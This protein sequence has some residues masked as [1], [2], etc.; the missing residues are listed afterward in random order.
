LFLSN[1]GKTV[2]GS[3]EQRKGDNTVAA[4]LDPEARKSIDPLPNIP[5]QKVFLYEV[6]QLSD[7]DESRAAQL[8]EVLQSFLGL[9]QP[10]LPMI[11]YKPGK[12]HNLATLQKVNAKK[13]DICDRKYGKLSR[14]I[15]LRF[16]SIFRRRIL[17]PLVRLVLSTRQLLSL[18]P[19]QLLCCR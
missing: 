16:V 13:I 12:E 18:N 2:D 19:N 1:L 15:V 5:A 6:S 10:I 3:R 9:R 11:W 4:Y 17:L 8:R 7:G 14:G